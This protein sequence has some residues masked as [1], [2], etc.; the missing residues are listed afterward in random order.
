MALAA[1]PMFNIPEVKADTPSRRKMSLLSTRSNEQKIRGLFYLDG[2]PVEITVSNGIIADI[3]RLAVDVSELDGVYVGPGLIDNQVNGY[4]GVSFALGRSDF[5]LTVG[6]ALKATKEYWK[7][8]VTTYLPTLT[9]NSEDLLKHNFAVMAETV[10]NKEFLGSIPYFHLEGPYISPVDGYVGCHPKQYVHK[11]DWDEFMRFQE[12]AGGKIHVITVAPEIEGAAEFIR[13]CVR[14]GIIVSLGHH[15]APTDKVRMA[16]DMGASLCTH[17]GNGAANTVN[18][19]K[20]PFWSQLSD[21]RLNISI[22]CDGFHLLDEEIA[23]F[24][25]VKG[26]DRTIIISD[27]TNY[28]ALKPG[29]HLTG[30]GEKIVLHESGLLSYP[31]SGGLYGSASPL[32]QGIGTIMRA[33]GCSLGEAITMASTNTARLHNLTDRGTLEPGKRADIITFKTGIK[34]ISILSTYVKGQLVYEK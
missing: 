33:T 1:V 27:V 10:D 24:Y 25:A 23:T 3:R 4:A 9:T 7:K 16:A 18:R 20:N 22:I 14:Q 21:R 12:A 2:S 32:T 5:G 31:D 8:G 17:L 28:A 19:H 30:T 26:T 29:V 11:P 6:D 34:G 13:K 15:N